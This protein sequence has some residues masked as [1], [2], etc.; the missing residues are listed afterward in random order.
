MDA[1]VGLVVLLLLVFVVF[2]VVIQDHDYKEANRHFRID[3]TER[4]VRGDIDADKFRE[5]MSLKGK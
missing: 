2:Y 4:F 5:I 1:F 3:I